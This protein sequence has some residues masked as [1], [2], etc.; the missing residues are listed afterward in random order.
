MQVTERKKAEQG[1]P[2]KEGKEKKQ[3]SKEM[4]KK[5]NHG[6]GGGKER[7]GQKVRAQ[8]NAGKGAI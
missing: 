1:D 3:G 4:K 8:K 6:E 7:K 5:G 2:S